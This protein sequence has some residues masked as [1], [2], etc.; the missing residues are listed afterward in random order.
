MFATAQV[1]VNMP[2]ST[3][4]VFIFV[5]L[6]I[7]TCKPWPEDEKDAHERTHVNLQAYADRFAWQY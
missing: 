5:L 3:L 6:S 4:L 7:V 2:K 1:L